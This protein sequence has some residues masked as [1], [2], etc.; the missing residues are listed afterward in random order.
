MAKKGSNLFRPI[1]AGMLFGVTIG[2]NVAVDFKATGRQATG[3]PRLGAGVEVGM[4]RG[5]HNVSWTSQRFKKLTDKAI[6]W[7]KVILINR[8][9]Y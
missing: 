1:L 9:W 4:L 5:Y 6:N 8:K 3:P 7:P 2:Q